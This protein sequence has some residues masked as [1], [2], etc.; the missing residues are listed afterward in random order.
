MF[1]R[2]DMS[3]I[4]VERGFFAFSPKSRRNLGEFAAKLQLG[5]SQKKKSL[6]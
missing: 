4:G 3:L 5:P 2:L 1:K 6:Y